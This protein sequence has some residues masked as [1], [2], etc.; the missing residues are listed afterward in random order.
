MNLDHAVAFVDN[1][2]KVC[3][4][5]LVDVERGPDGHLDRAEPEKALRFSPCASGLPGFCRV[6]AHPP[7]IREIF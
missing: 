5:S 7:R 1:V 3:S 2:N 4:T 6:L